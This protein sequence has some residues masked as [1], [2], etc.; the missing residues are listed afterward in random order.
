MKNENQPQTQP[1][2]E[3][4]PPAPQAAIEDGPKNEPALA[5]VEFIAPYAIEEFPLG[6]ILIQH[7]VLHMVN[8]EDL[9]EALKRYARQDWSNCPEYAGNNQLAILH[10]QREH[11]SFIMCV[12]G[13]FKDRCGQVFAITTTFL[14]PQTTVY[15]LPD[16][17]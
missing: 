2:A 3:G 1:F 13:K 9:I 16:I 10:R 12:K 8:A 4:S 7:E 5:N 15:W 14:N 6:N 11:K 17:F